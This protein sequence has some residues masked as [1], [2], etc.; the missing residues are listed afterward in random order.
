MAHLKEE[1][2]ATQGQFWSNSGTI[3]FGLNFANGLKHIGS[4]HRLHP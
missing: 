3:P 1:T 4:L 2:G